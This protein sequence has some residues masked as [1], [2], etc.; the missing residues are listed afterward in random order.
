MN[1]L[2]AADL[3]LLA[4]LKQQARDLKY[5][6]KPARCVACGANLH[7]FFS[8]KT[9]PDFCCPICGEEQFSED[10]RL[11]IW[12]QYGPGFFITA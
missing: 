2:S 7:L 4:R 8:P 1:A 3:E 10:Q 11:A 9:Q 6:I 12:A 5:P